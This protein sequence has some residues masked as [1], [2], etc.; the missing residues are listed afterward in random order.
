MKKIVL[1]VVAI[2]ALNGMLISCTDEHA[3]ESE[4]SSMNSGI[5]G[6]DK[7]IPDEDTHP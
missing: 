4:F 3:D 6:E 1:I 5:D 2:V 7:G